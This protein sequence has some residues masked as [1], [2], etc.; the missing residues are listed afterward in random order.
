MRAPC[1]L[2]VRS[3]IVGMGVF[4]ALGVVAV[5]A[6]QRFA[7]SPL[8]FLELV[9][10]FLPFLFLPLLV[11]VPLAGLSRSRTLWGAVLVLLML[12]GG[13]YGP[14]FLPRP[15]RSVTA[16]EA[17]LSVMT[18][19]LRYEYYD[20]AR[21]VATLV[22]SGADVIA[23]QE[24]APSV[25]VAL[26]PAVAAAYPHAVWPAGGAEVGLLSRYPIAAHA[27]FRPAEAGRTALRATLEVA[28][29][30]T[31]FFVLHPFPPGVL[32]LGRSR[33]PRGLAYGVPIDAQMR[34]VVQR[35]A[36][37]DGPVV[38]LGD[39]NMSEQSRGYAVLVD[40]LT[41]AYREAGWGFG[42]TF[43]QDVRLE[44]GRG[45]RRMIGYVPGPFV[46]IDYIFRSEDFFAERARVTCEGASD[47]C[48]LTADLVLVR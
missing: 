23:L 22:A 12:F 34:D 6:V 8:P 48:Y 47:H 30:P 11:W 17:R 16:G 15:M 19:N 45:I 40:A 26:R 46:R 35:V 27:W 9:N 7:P 39:F 41:D 10:A 28:E 21:L 18:F 43:P 29:V 42:F 5:W 24:L 44:G 38:V 13:L 1:K 14:L 4:Y 33:V 25:V 37:F 20:P 36:S 3:A 31:A 2:T 32:W